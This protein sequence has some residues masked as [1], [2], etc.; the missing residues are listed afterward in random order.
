MTL[1]KP[2]PMI[3]G[4]D[5]ETHK[6]VECG[7]PILVGRKMCLRCEFRIVREAR[8]REQVK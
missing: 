3:V 7:R 4:R 6:D 2:C 1:T 5:V 8:Q